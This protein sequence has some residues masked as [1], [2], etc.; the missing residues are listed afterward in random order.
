[1]ANLPLLWLRL[2]AVRRM[3]PLIVVAWPVAACG[4]APDEATLVLRVGPPSDAATV[5]AAADVV[6]ARLAG[7]DLPVELVVEG[8]RI[9]ATLPPAEPGQELVALLTDPGR[10][11]LLAVP[12]GVEPSESDALD[13]S[14]EVLLEASGPVAT[15]QEPDAVGNPALSFTFGDADAERLAALT[16]ARVGQS[17]V[18]AFDDEILAVPI[19]RAPIEDG[20]L[21]LT[22]G[23]VDG[24]SPERLRELAA[25]ISS[26]PLQA[27]VTEDVGS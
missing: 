1:M 25:L 21:M 18:L 11:R 24:L 17:V 9:T 16:R 2:G 10:L 26:G 8:D 15:V 5:A 20:R 27:P 13:P 22:L 7:L 4:V 6:R 3:L 23:G 19:M 14:W 12:D